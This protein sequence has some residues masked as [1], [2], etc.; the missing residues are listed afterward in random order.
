MAEGGERMFD[1]HIH[2]EKGPYTVGWA[3]CFIA[4]AQRK[5]IGEIWLLEHCY[6]F[7]EFVP[8]YADLREKNSFIDQW[9][10]RKAGTRSLTEYLRLADAMRCR[11]YPVKLRFG[12]EICY[13]EGKESFIRQQTAPL[14]LDFLAGSVH[15]ADSFAFDHRADLWQ[16]MDVDTVYRQVFRHSSALADSGLFTG[17]THPDSVSLFGHTPSYSLTETY[18][19]LARK[20]AAQGMYAE[21]NSGVYRRCPDTAHPG[22]APEMLAAMRKYGVRIVTASDAHRP[23]DVGEGIAELTEPL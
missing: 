1:A 15:F 23:E 4:E 13:L 22:M 11:T 20:L 9:L 12:L 3:E 16:G 7:P 21:Q 10:A 6:L 19:E 18:G 8:M 5:G 14:G 2:L 17:I